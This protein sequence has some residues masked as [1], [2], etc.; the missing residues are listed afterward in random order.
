MSGKRAKSFISYFKQA[1]SENQCHLDNVDYTSNTGQCLKMESFSIQ[2]SISTKNHF[3]ED[4]SFS[5]NENETV[6]AL[7]KKTGEWKSF[8]CDYEYENVDQNSQ[9]TYNF[10]ECIPS[11]NTLNFKK[12]SKK[13][14]SEDIDLNEN[15]ETEFEEFDSDVPLISV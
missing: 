1:N 14:D 2:D 13:S 7:D 10:R 15:E 4:L 6:F 11:F 12:K 8:E 9:P 5:D 3:Q